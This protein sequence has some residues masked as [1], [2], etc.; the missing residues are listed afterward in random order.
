MKFLEWTPLLLGRVQKHRV[1]PSSLHREQSENCSVKQRVG[2]AIW[3]I[4]LHRVKFQP[5]RGSPSKRLP[6][7]HHL[8]VLVFLPESWFVRNVLHCIPYDGFIQNW[9]LPLHWDII[10]FIFQH[11]WVLSLRLGWISTVPFDGEVPKGNGQHDQQA[12]F[13]LTLL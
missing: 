5:L 13:L 2:W 6:I 8:K 11:F 12:G 9:F 7:D 1:F 10:A 4:W 3:G